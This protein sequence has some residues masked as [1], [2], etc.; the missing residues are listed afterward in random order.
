MILSFHSVVDGDNIFM[1]YYILL[2][3]NFQLGQENL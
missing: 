1:G 3:D 2:I